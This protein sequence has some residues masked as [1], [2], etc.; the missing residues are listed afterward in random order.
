MVASVAVSKCS[1][2]ASLNSGVLINF[3]LREMPPPFF[4]CRLPLIQLEGMGEHLSQALVAGVFWSIFAPWKT[5][6]GDTKFCNCINCE[7]YL[8]KKASPAF[9]HQ[10]HNCN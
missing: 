5:A 8:R 10:I 6:A 2:T 4:R 9:P 1:G 3:C 7:K